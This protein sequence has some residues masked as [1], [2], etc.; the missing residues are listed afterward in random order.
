M[1]WT[2]YKN[3]TL[4]ISGTGYM[5]NYTQSADQP[6]NN[7]RNQIKKVIIKKDVT[8]VGDWSFADYPNLEQAI[9]SSTVNKNIGQHAFENCPN[10]KLHYQFGLK[11]GSKSNKNKN[12]INHATK[13]LS[14]ED[15]VIII[16][17]KVYL[18][19]GKLPSE[20]KKF[21]Y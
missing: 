17:G 10:L 15:Y 21:I 8:S 13:T 18:K 12:V 19:N 1:K 5:E 4:T 14:H 3:G 11:S 6:W 2:L 7:N 20:I 9:I 16:G